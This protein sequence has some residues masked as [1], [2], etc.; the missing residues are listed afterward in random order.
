M[1]YPMTNSF[2]QKLSWK[3]TKKISSFPNN[4]AKTNNGLV[5]LIQG[6]CYIHPNESFVL[7]IRLRI[8]TV[9]LKIRGKAFFK[10]KSRT[11]VTFKLQFLTFAIYQWQRLGLKLVRYH[12]KNVKNIKS[13]F[14][15]FFVVAYLLSPNRCHC[16]IAKVKNYNLNVTEIRYPDFPMLFPGIF[17]FTVGILIHILGLIFET[18][19]SSQTVCN[20]RKT[21]LLIN[22]GQT[23]LYFVN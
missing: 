14:H 16:Q 11:S 4:F 3:I 20:E 15:I 6:N 19:Q 1:D 12:E 17:N 18:Q 8:P 2:Q 21:F 5:S 22:L 23:V 9:K 7:W 10:S 13:V